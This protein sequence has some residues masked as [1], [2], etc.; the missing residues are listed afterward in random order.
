ME[1]A[2]YYSSRPPLTDFHSLLYDVMRRATSGELEAEEVTSFLSDLSS[3]LVMCTHV[4]AHVQ[5]IRTNACT[6]IIVFR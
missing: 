3:N 4:H 1:R 6:G 2:T 5:Y